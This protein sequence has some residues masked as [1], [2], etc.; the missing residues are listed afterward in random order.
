M[1]NAEDIKAKLN[2][3]AVVIGAGPGGPQAIEEIL[4]SIDPNLP[5]VYIILQ[6]M[7][8]GFTKVF[9][10]QLRHICT[11]PV[12]E[13]IDGEQLHIPCVLVVPTGHSISLYNPPEADA[14]VFQIFVEY[15]DISNKKA[16]KP[17]NASMISAANAFGKNTIGVLLTGYG[18]DGIDG[19]KAIADA[20]GT[21]IVEDESS[22]IIFELPFNAINAGVVHHTTPLYQISEKI[23]SKIR[24]EKYAAA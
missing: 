12:R 20:G 7:R 14:N 6:K 23:M 2:F 19:M 9:A 4:K 18:D 17:I 16:M 10:E 1:L 3:Y 21:T 22:C 13:P 11:I 8:T 5:I 24:G 15:V